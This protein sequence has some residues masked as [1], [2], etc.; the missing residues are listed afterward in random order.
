[1]LQSYVNWL[2]ESTIDNLC[3]NKEEF[4]RFLNDLN[5]F[6]IDLALVFV[7]KE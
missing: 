4:V 3:D 2:I 5:T 7:C 1:M 6:K